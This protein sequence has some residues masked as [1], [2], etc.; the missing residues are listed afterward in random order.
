MSNVKITVQERQEV[1][2]RG[3]AASS[4]IVY[5]PG[6]ATT[7]PIGVPTLCQTYDE[8]TSTFGSEPYK[9]VDADIDGFAKA[10]RCGLKA[11]NFDRG[12]IMAAELLNTGLQIMFERVD[13]DVVSDAQP[14]VAV[15]TTDEVDRMTALEN[16]VYQYTTCKEKESEKFAFKFLLR[17][18]SLAQEDS[19]VTDTVSVG[20]RM[21]E[22]LENATVTLGAITFTKTTGVTVEGNKI[23]LAGV[24]A[25]TL[26]YL[27]FTAEVNVAVTTPEEGKIVKFAVVGVE[28]ESA[29][30]P[31]VET[32]KLNYLYEQFVTLFNK[33]EDKGQYSVK[34]ITSGGYPTYFVGDEQI[35]KN[36]MGVASVRGDAIAIIDHEYDT[37]RSLNYKDSNSIYYAVNNTFKSEADATYAAMFT[38][39]GKYTL[40]RIALPVEKDEDKKPILPASFGYL[41]SLATAIKTS[42]NWLAM[43]GVSRGQ[44]SGYTP[45]DGD[46]IITNVIAENYQPKQADDA[47]LNM[48]GIN[49]ITNIRPYGQCIWGNRTLYKTPK[50]G[51]EPLNFLNTRNMISD[52]KKLAYTTAKELMFEQNSDTLWLK[53]KSGV[54]PLL[55]QL[56]SGNGISDYKLIKGATHYGTDGNG[57]QLARNELA[58]VIR[59]YPM[60]AVEYFEITVVVTDED[61]AVE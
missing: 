28:G 54:S 16:G 42:P 4:D 24:H 14:I 25:H 31:V 34:Y 17:P 15:A 50:L 40:T 5:I 27:V 48:I 21:V 53:F 56:R 41:K 39:Y 45:I 13:Q 1:N 10:D 30:A 60:Y 61:V 11:G 18:S 52:I 55:E 47:G 26:D 38:P 37:S 3:S 32:S 6:L 22:E 7:G 57:P 46:P 44:V 51:G 49:A 12:Y 2:P 9:L 19:V 35:A 29:D 33:L 43:A 36:M 23:N 8:F 59:I 58:A 20:V